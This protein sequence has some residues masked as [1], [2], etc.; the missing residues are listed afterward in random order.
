MPSPCLPRRH[1][2]GDV[3]WLPTSSGLWEVHFHIPL[4][5]ELCMPV[6][7]P[8]VWMSHAHTPV[9]TP[10]GAWGS[11]IL[12]PFQALPRDWG[13][14]PVLLPDPQTHLRSLSSFSIK[15]LSSRWDR[16][17]GPS[18]ASLV[19]SLTLSSLV[20]SL[21]YFRNLSKT[22]RMETC[23]LTHRVFSQVFVIVTGLGKFKSQEGLI[24][25]FFLS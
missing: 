6:S 18:K 22:T 20:P 23:A 19:P 4:P 13:R 21:I 14:S 25:F 12:S 7:W 9:L 2:V 17:Q 15:G 10:G 24:F 5:E 3:L 16:A 8:N 11:K 1:S